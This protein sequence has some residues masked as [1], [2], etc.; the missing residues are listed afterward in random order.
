MGGSALS[1]LTRHSVTGLPHAGAPRAWRHVP[2]IGSSSSCTESCTGLPA[3]MT[4]NTTV[5]PGW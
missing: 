5:S 1:P 2:Y 3:R 4:E